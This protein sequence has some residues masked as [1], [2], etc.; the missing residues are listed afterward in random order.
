[1]EE[2]YLQALGTE[3]SR[4]LTFVDGDDAVVRC[5]VAL[6]PAVRTALSDSPRVRVEP[7]EKMGT[8]FIVVG[9]GGS[10]VVDGQLDTRITRSA[11]SLAIEIDARLQE[12]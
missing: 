7:E 2:R 12:L 5:S 10:V 3:L 8:G 9:A 1:M 11:S 4:A 6:E